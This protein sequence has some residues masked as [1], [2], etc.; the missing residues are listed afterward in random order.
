MPGTS[1]TIPS[2]LWSESQGPGVILCS[3]LTEPFWFTSI[4]SSDKSPLANQNLTIRR[5]TPFQGPLS[6]PGPG[7]PSL[8][9]P[10]ASLYEHFQ[11]LSVGKNIVGA[12]TDRRFCPFYLLTSLQN[13]ECQRTAYRPVHITVT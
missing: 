7:K 10:H 3:K 11:L 13:V 4:S 6:S 8:P 5:C 1:R 12:D 9:I 2:C